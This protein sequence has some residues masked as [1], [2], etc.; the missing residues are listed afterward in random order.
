MQDVIANFSTNVYQPQTVHSLPCVQLSPLDA[1]HCR[2]RFAG[3]SH[4]D[5]CDA[6][7]V[8]V[9]AHFLVLIAALVSENGVAGSAVIAAGFWHA[10][11]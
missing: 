8:L 1:K 4:D 10:T 9:A 5:D 2:D 11:R 7:R 6:Q 3:A